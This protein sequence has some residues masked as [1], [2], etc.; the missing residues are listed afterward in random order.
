MASARPPR[1]L[2]WRRVLTGA[3][4]VVATLEVIDAFIIDFPIAAIVVA[5]LFVVGAWWLARPGLAPV[6]YTGIL[7]LV[8]LVL[9][10]FAFGGI[11]ALSDPA[12][13]GEFARSAAFTIATAIGVIAAGSVLAA[14]TM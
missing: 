2:N 10:L 1:R 4:I 8:E 11:Q 6:I 13:L 9:V 14:R 7:C 3:A 5:V 12:S